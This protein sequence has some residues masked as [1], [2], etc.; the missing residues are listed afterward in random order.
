M[1]QRSAGNW[2]LSARANI[3]FLKEVPVLPRL[4]A[5]S[6]MRSNNSLAL[7]IKSLGHRVEQPILTN[8][9]LIDE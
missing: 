2:K 4:E 7:G 6:F 9:P 8:L 5:C 1:K 3:S